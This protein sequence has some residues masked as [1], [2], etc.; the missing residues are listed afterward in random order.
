MVLVHCTSTSGKK[1]QI[2]RQLASVGQ[3][4]V[5]DSLYGSH[6]PPLEKH[7]VMLHAS[8]LSFTH[9][10]TQKPLRIEAPLP[11]EWKHVFLGLLDGE[12]SSEGIR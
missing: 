3:S 11:G 2:R 12:Y 4:I 10:V 8:A 9:P 1:H 7:S 5:G 6:K